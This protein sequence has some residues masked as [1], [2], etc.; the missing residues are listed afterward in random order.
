MPNEPHSG[1]NPV[2]ERARHESARALPPQRRPGVASGMRILIVE[3]G[4]LTA[5]RWP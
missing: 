4:K 5:P 3:D 1:A 2:I